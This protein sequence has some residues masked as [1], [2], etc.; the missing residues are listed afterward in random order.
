VTD[1][2][3]DW[4]AERENIPSV[5]ILHSCNWRA[6]LTAT[7]SSK[8]THENA[9]RVCAAFLYLRSDYIFGVSPPEV[10]I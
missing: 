4:E 8:V 10:D 9:R 6:P 3:H 1:Y 7:A 2:W 5:S